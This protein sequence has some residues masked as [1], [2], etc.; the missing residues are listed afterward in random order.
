MTRSFRVGESTIYRNH[1]AWSVDNERF[2]T[3]TNSLEMRNIDVYEGD[4]TTA[5]ASGDDR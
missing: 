4:V 5:E 1:D 2:R 3:A